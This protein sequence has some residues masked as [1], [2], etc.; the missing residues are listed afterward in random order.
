M[1]DF[2]KDTSI[3]VLL[4]SLFVAAIAGCTWHFLARTRLPW[5]G[6]R[7]LPWATAF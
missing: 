6:R 2:M 4:C 5:L 7:F 3:A 1:R